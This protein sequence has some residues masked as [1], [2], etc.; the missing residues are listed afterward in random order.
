MQALNEFFC[1]DNALRL[2]LVD[3]GLDHCLERC[4]QSF[5]RELKRCK[6]IFHLC[7][8][9]STPTLRIG[10]L[11]RVVQLQLLH[12]HLGDVDRV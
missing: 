5:L 12:V 8:R 2:D 4:T 3:V 1:V 11:Q 10:L 9:H 7:D 6:N